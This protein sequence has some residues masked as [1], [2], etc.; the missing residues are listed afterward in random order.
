MFTVVDSVTLTF[1]VK[2]RFWFH[3]IFSWRSELQ[4]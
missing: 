2:S 1:R 3:A 4:Y